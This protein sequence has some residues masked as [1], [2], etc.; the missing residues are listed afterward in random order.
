MAD[1][2]GQSL[3]AL[4]AP[5]THGVGSVWLGQ[6]FVLD[7]LTTLTV[8]GGDL[9]GVELGTGVI[10]SYAQHPLA[11][12]S[13]ALTVQA[14]TGNRLTLGLGV[15]NP[16]LVEGQLGLEAGRA[17]RHL[18]EYLAVLLPLLRGETVAYQGDTLSAAGAVAIPEAQPPS[19][20]V[21]AHRPA[22]LRLA[23][24]VADG[25]LTNW[26]TPRAIA[27][28]IEP[29]LRAAAT[30]AGRQVRPRLVAMVLASVTDDP[31]GHRRWVGET[32]ARSGEQAGYRATLEQGGAAGPQDAV[33]VGG[34]AQVEGQLRRLLD[35]G[36]TQVV[37]Y[38]FGS[39][40]EWEGT[41]EALAAVA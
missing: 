13:Q 16:S 14:A 12:A 5:A 19:V 25:A 33:V 34:P 7:P 21:A 39:P 41:V 40:E 36:A 8:L 35:A 24:G 4:R 17:A 3:P 10:V 27:D 26:A 32:F 29:A 6:H 1:D 37:A 15:S 38:P 28:H 2:R 18:R 9:P 23:G 20:L 11:L 31:E 22:R 30:D